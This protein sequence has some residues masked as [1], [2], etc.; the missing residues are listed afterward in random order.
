[1]RQT[2]L[3]GLV[4]ATT[5][6]VAAFAAELKRIQVPTSKGAPQLVVVMSGKEVIAE[7][8]IIKPGTLNLEVGDVVWH[9]VPGG[10]NDYSC[11]DGSK[12]ELLAEGKSVLK[13]S[14]DRMLIQSAEQNLKVKGPN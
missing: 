10:K 1:M 11:T 12:L 14:G 13:V 4:I 7:V 9:S 5:V 3:V 2:K 8:K 6:A